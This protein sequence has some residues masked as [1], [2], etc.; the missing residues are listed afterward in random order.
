MVGMYS[1]DLLCNTIIFN[2]HHHIKVDKNANAVKKGIS[3]MQKIPF[4]VE[5]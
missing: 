5:F 3:L 2:I 1:N 4:N